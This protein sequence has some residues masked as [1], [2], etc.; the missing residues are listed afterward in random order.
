MDVR[1]RQAVVERPFQLL[2]YQMLWWVCRFD[3]LGKLVSAHRAGV[4]RQA[5]VETGEAGALMDVHNRQA[6]SSSCGGAPGR[7]W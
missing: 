4:N 3:T 6:G 5:V 7:L 1:T 2:D